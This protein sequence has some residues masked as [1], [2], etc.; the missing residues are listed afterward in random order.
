MTAA[1]MTPHAHSPDITP[2]QL[3]AIGARDVRIGAYLEALSGKP[4]DSADAALHKRL[5]ALYRARNQADLLKAYDTAEVIADAMAAL[6]DGREA[7]V[8]RSNA[9]QVL[10]AMRAEKLEP[11]KADDAVFAGLAFVESEP[12]APPTRTPLR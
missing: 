1:R 4:S 11:A 5:T 2:E 8:A 3:A 10:S 9:R 7:E 12:A 6:I